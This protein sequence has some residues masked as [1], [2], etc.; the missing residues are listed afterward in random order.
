[1][2]AILQAKYV[3]IY[4][5][6]IIYTYMYMYV[7]VCICMYMYVYILSQCERLRV[8]LRTQTCSLLWVR[9][10]VFILLA[11]LPAARLACTA[12]F[13]CT[14]AWLDVL[15]PNDKGR[16]VFQLPN[17]TMLWAYIF[18][19]VGIHHIAFEPVRVPPMDETPD[20]DFFPMTHNELDFFSAM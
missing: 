13:D 16:Q 1:M 19:F 4:V 20:T 8:L 11:L 5:Y 14:H 15:M 2:Q 12:L 18:A 17:P 3:H 10:V 9:L 7:Y 6:T